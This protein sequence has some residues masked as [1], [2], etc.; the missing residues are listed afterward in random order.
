M[1]RA[2]FPWLPWTQYPRR[3][4]VAWA[5]G[6]HP[7]NLVSGEPNVPLRPPLLRLSRSRPFSLRFASHSL[8]LSALLFSSFLYLFIHSILL[9][10]SFSLQ[11]PLFPYKTPSLFFSL[12]FP[13]LYFSFFHL[14]YFSFPPLPLH[15]PLPFYNPFIILSFILSYRKLYFFHPL[16][17]FISFLLLC[18]DCASFFYSLPPPLFFSFPL[19]SLRFLN[20]YFSS[21]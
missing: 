12:S 21:R 16:Y 14:L 15:R 13:A 2:P 6:C 17:I 1:P 5:A 19:C 8:F 4:G 9:F 20:P 10:P 18:L 7:S 3:P 11:P